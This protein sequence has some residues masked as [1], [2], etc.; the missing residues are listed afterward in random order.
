MSTPLLD[1]INRRKDVGHCLI[2][3]FRTG[4]R[5]MADPG[6]EHLNAKPLPRWLERLTDQDRTATIYSDGGNR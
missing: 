2:C 4:L 6:H 1:R 3:Y 5:V